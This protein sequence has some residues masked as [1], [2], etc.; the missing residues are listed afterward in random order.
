MKVLVLYSELAGYFMAC[1]RRYVEKYRAEAHV[2]R[3]PVNPEAPFKFE[4][5]PGI[6]Y[7]E[8]NDYDT[9]GLLDLAKK[10]D[11]DVIYISGWIDKPYLAVA[12]HFFK[13]GKPVIAAFDTQWRG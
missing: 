12:R 3:W 2:V 4:G 8:R 11:P 9:K 10:V 7:Y 13:A 1:V 5:E 6:T